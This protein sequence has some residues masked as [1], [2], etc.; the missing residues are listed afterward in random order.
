MLAALDLKL[1]R[2][3]AKIKGQIIAVS[4]VMAC[5]IAM[6]ITT[7]GLIL[8]VESTRN[9]YYSSRR[10][11]DLFCEL[12]RA[13][14]ALRPRLT[15][16]PGVAAIETRVTGRITLDLPGLAE[17]ADGMMLSLPEDRAQQLNLLFVRIG[18]LPEI[19]SHNEV[20][21]GEAFAQ[22][23]G[24]KPGDDID[25]TIR[26]ARERLH[27]VG[28]ALSPEFVFE[29]RAGE[30]FPDN[31]RFG[32]F[33]MN[34][35][36][37]A[38]AFDLQGGFNSVLVDL[39]P[40]QDPAPIRAELDRILDDYGGRI[41]YGH[42]EHA[43]AVRL[44][45]ELQI[46]HSLSFAF[47]TVFLSIAAFM[48]SA[49]LTRL[50]RLQREQ[51]AQLKALGYSAIQ[52]GAHFMKYALVIVVAAVL[53]GGTAGLMLGQGFV[54]VYQQFF[55]FPA[56]EFRPDW[57]IIGVAFLVSAAA[58]FVG[59]F[60][61]VRQAVR[62]PPAEAM[63]PEPPAS[64]NPSIIERLGLF[65]FAS[66]TFRMALRN[67]HRRPWQAIFTTFGLALATAI[68]IVPGAMREGIDYILSFQWSLVARQDA[69]VSLI[70]PSSSG[71]LNDLMHL[72]GVMSAEPFRSVP[73]RLRFGHHSRRLSVTGLTR[74]ATLNRLLDVNAQPV[75][76]PLDGLLMSAKLAEVLDAK[77]GDKVI[78]EVQEG[79]RPVI[80]ATIQGTVA[81]YAGIAA[82]MEIG[83]LQRILREG[84]TMSGAHLAVDAAQWPQFLE[85]VEE[86][87]RIASL[88][89]TAAVQK[90]FQ[91][92]TG[93]MI[94][95]IQWLY[96]IFAT[97]VAFGV[98]YN[99]AR[100]SLSER[101]RDL[102]TLRVVGFTRRE[103]AGVMISELLLL[104]VLAIPV[105]LWIGKQLA[106]GIV[107]A[108]STETVR[109]PLVISSGSYGTAVL[110]VLIASAISFAV[111]SRRIHHLDLLG[112]LKARE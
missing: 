9:A 72:P 111:V 33:W 105:G 61:A 18:R 96:F 48:S 84:G 3:L 107:T 5:G 45:D 4:L 44:D 39:A 1:F 14:N 92:T 65:R 15:E 13:P 31:R 62:L 87:P 8:S 29:A 52:I 74:N 28:I 94:G 6:M 102:A 70:E 53:V 83:A 60:G 20:V 108:V 55:R 38:T 101:S 11:A 103:V 80:E 34:E 86:S 109:L 30:T 22:A 43:S 68:P 69:T 59:V 90:T 26:G 82:Y 51:I 58:A 47:P 27:I 7:R 16:I 104:T 50:I 63:R 99:S 78:I 57:P 88:G 54:K 37:L 10:F 32:V 76:L 41:T 36:E 21:V 89:I 79:R 25:V 91:K 98:V 49:V 19:G 97:I 73:A 12:K 2:D 64:F 110:I 42:R 95:K 75:A 35:R 106:T 85:K 112:V 67:L 66:P 71:T 46:L 24:F 23:H 40:G 100:I 77:P 93:E 81:D 17:P 56:L